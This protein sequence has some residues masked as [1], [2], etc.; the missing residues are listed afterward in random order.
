MISVE[1]A[2]STS[3]Q[4]YFV[5]TSHLWPPSIHS[6][7]YIVLYLGY[8]CLPIMAAPFATRLYFELH[9][10]NKQPIVELQCQ[11]PHSQWKQL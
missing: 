8:G 4:L 9:S 11:Q 5:K 1:L 2:N 10:T 7:N 6:Q 3:I